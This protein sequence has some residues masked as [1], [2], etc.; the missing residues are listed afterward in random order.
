MSTSDVTNPTLG[1][2]HWQVAPGRSELGFLTKAM[3][4]MKVHGHYDDYSG[5]LTVDESGNATGSLTIAAESIRTGIKKRDVHLRS[6][7][8]FAA[9]AHPHMTFTLS[10]L[11]QNPDGTL[12]V[13]GSLSIRGHEQPI[14]AV[15][16][17]ATEGPGAVRLSA[18]FPV[19]HHAAG[20][21][22][23]KLPAK[24]QIEAGLVLTHTS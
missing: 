24:V 5:E 10:A 6:A 23:K 21:E 17:V 1:A 14:D 2:G 12:T 18:S 20:F 16:T 9:E 4:F 7:D 22:F 8:F 11:T 15:A 13:T 19:D 3:G